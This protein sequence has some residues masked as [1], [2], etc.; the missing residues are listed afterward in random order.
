MEWWVILLILFGSFVFLLL[1][2][3]P[4]AFAF[5]FINL[6]GVYFFMMGGVGLNQFILSIYDSVTIFALLPVPLFILMGEVMFHSGIAPRM[7]DV[8]DKWLGRLPGRLGLVA[9]GGGTIFATLSGSAA[10]GT[11]MLGSVLVPD[12]ERRGYK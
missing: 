2:G 8:V 9:V 5:L 11:A 10:S 3:V 12:M 7:M 4:V 6:L 1:I